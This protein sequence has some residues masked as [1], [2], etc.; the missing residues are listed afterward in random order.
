[1]V[2]IWFLAYPAPTPTRL[3]FNSTRRLAAVALLV[4]LYLF[5]PL[6]FLEGPYSTDI[7]SIATLQEKGSRVGKEVRM[8]R[9][10]YLQRDDGD[11]VLTF[12]NEPLRVVGDIRAEKST[13]VSLIGEFVDA[14][15]IRIK[16]LHE[17]HSYWRDLAS[18]IGLGIFSLLWAVSLVRERRSQR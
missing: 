2:G 14:D 12:A 13:Q 11:V 16:H 15:S 10:N 17:Y 1:M 8:D 3:L 18:Y 4:S 5:S 7:N 9:E 6:A